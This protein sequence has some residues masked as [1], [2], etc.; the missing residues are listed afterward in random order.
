VILYFIC[1]SLVVGCVNPLGGNERFDCAPGVLDADDS[2]R[3]LEAASI[4]VVFAGLDCFRH[5]GSNKGQCFR[6]KPIVLGVR[7]ESL[8]ESG[9]VCV[10]ER[11]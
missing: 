5:F 3:V 4:V 10:L 7:L 2:A 1:V 6:R 9:S 8:G 11:D